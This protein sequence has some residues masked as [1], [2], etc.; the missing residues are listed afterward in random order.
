MVSEVHASSYAFLYGG[1]R[2]TYAKVLQP[3]WSAT[4]TLTDRGF[5][6]V[7]AE[8]G[9]LPLYPILPLPGEH[10]EWEHAAARLPQACR[11]DAWQSFIDELPN[12]NAYSLADEHLPKANLCLGAVA[13]AIG[14]IAQLPVPEC[15]LSPWFQ[16]AH[17]LDNLNVSLP[18]PHL[19]IVNFNVLPRTS[20]ALSQNEN[21]DMITDPWSQT[22]AAVSLTG[23]RTERNFW[24]GT[25]SLE[26][27]SR[28]LPGLL[29]RAQ[30]ATI[31]SDNASLRLEL[32]NLIQLLDRMTCALLRS[33]L[34][35]LSEWCVDPVDFSRSVDAATNAVVDGEKTGSGTQSPIIHTLDAFFERCFQSTRLSKIAKR[36]NSW[37]PRLH[38][39]FIAAIREVSV[40]DYI[41]GLPPSRERG[42]LLH[43]YMRA[44]ESFADDNGFL[45]KHRLRLIAFI[46]L[47]TKIG[48]K[49]T[50][51][52]LVLDSW[53]GR[54]WYKIDAAMEEVTRER[55]RRCKTLYH[56]V[57]ICS[58]TP[59]GTKN[60]FAQRI[61]FN[62]EGTLLYRPGDVLCILPENREGFVAEMLTALNIDDNRIVKVK[63][64]L[65]I[66]NLLDRGFKDMKS[67]EDN[68]ITITMAQ[69]LRYA[70]IQPFISKTLNPLQNC[71]TSICRDRANIDSIVEPLQARSYSIAS[72]ATVTPKHIEI[73]VGKTEYRKSTND[74]NSSLN[75]SS[76]DPRF[77]IQVF[78][79][80]K[81]MSVLSKKG[82]NKL[83]DQEVLHINSSVSIHTD[84][85][86]SSSA[87]VHG[88]SSSF[89]STSSPG[90]IVYSRIIPKVRFRL[91]SEAKAPIVM[92]GLGTGIAPFMSFI[93]E[94]MHEKRATGHVPHKIWLVLG[95]QTPDH[96]PFLEELEEAVCKH[97]I[98][99]LSIAFSRADMDYCEEESTK[100]L[101][102]RPG[103]RKRVQ[104][105]FWDYSKT[106][107]RF[108]DTIA[109]NG[110]VYLCGKPQ[111]E[112]FIREAI[113][114][115]A[116][117]FGRSVVQAEFPDSTESIETL[118][119]RF[120]YLLA[121]QHRLHISTYNGGRQSHPSKDL[122]PSEVAQHRSMNSCF[123]S[124][125][126]YVYNLTAFL[127]LHPG[128][129]KIL[130]DKAGRDITKDFNLA[131]G[132]DPNPIV[133]MI[134]PYRIGMVYRFHEGFCDRILPLMREWSLPLLHGVL[135]QRSAF[136][137]EANNFPE[138]ERL[139]SNTRWSSHLS[140][141]AG[142]ASICRNFW[143]T[144]ERQLF[145]YIQEEMSSKR[146]GTFLSNLSTADECDLNKL[147]KAIRASREVGINMAKARGAA[148]SKPEAEDVMKQCSEFM[149]K[150]VDVFVE[151]QR[152]VECV[153]R[154]SSS[155]AILSSVY[156]SLSDSVTR[157]V[158]IG[159]DQSYSSL[160]L[161][162]LC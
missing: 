62:T 22:E 117:Q 92:I 107:K 102:F 64:K 26:H 124:F 61:V 45:G 97:K 50:A 104:N 42:Q 16:I 13:H 67:A 76:A 131:H 121:A 101:A 146:L 161:T 28:S 84:G 153:L 8:S 21:M 110:H 52:S 14:N 115:A 32:I 155:E 154:K 158:A 123:V 135:E 157:T 83:N 69:F 39:D 103:S 148:A 71:I 79:A 129:A 30:Q 156:H 57:I 6:W 59:A 113:T 150:A 60:S 130:F 160:S 24:H 120:P 145:E 88:V 49:Q 162:Y 139:Q 10:I 159:I 33:D 65:W 85:K 87:V 81:N 77:P 35:P 19:A 17:R 111:L 136:L 46:E 116:K 122:M 58:S 68:S 147:Q 141:P 4:P 90:T 80:E 15:V 134:E 55:M 112:P 142:Q 1:R 94:L 105:L 133:A 75:M 29:A 106:L 72:S 47:G 34:R 43:L 93:K 137:M 114:K 44:L 82:K 96:I 118:S 99:Q 152:V 27:I 51:S 20:D 25:F 119:S 3:Q 54:I 23:S 11:T 144:H 40:L 53:K 56:P 128:G 7:G 78:Q 66:Q 36:E 95:V 91:P 2:P 5:A 125:R 73:V 63:A 89:L 18:Y 48:R 74:I 12:I 100:R 98:V 38:R 9:F 37:F 143:K 31:S 140:S 151:V 41:E 108:W 127:R 86:Q 126:G 138:L 149:D 132:R 70:S 109:D